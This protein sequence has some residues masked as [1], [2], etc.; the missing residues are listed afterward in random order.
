M[1][2]A[3]IRK[4]PKVRAPICILYGPSG[5][6]KTSTIAKIKN[7]IIVQ[8]EDGIGK[9]ESDHFDVAKSW[10]EFM[11]N[12]KSLRD[13]EH[14]YKCVGIDSLDW[15]EPLIWQKA[16]EDN[17]WKS[18][19][20]PGYGKGYVEVL[21]Y[22][23]EYT[24]ILNEL[25]NKGMVVM[26]IAHNQIQKVEDP[27]IEAYDRHTIKLH[28]KATD[29][30]VEHA[31]AVFFGAFKLG[32]VQVKGKGGNMTTKAVSG[33]RVVYTQNSVAYLAKN[34]YGLPEELPMDWSV[35]REEM[36]K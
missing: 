27:R 22:W 25:R 12:L 8:T 19:E 14:S 34:R 10:D 5:V 29:L 23:R 20:Q 21:K 1:S 7:S 31:D 6:G 18:I 24:D 13:E 9:N 11:S 3:A 17:G 32:Q 28:R 30:L 36:L 33:D 26:Q 35:I 4:K 2:L 15:L 16:C